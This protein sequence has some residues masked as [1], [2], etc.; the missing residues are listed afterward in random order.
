MNA[1]LPNDQLGVVVAHIINIR[2]HPSFAQE[3]KFVFRLPDGKI[4]FG[5]KPSEVVQ[6]MSDEKMSTPKSIASYRKA[7]MRRMRSS[8]P[9]SVLLYS[10]N[11]DFIKSL[12]EVG[13]LV[14]IKKGG[15]SAQN[16]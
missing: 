15:T 2:T 10:T 14:D 11:L 3:A 16:R 5:N 1:V 6:M 13:Q 9:N 4:V 7:V 12:V 8:F